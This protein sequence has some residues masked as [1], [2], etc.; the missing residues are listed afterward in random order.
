MR[1][2]LLWAMLLLGAL[3]AHASV[4]GLEAGVP[5][6]SAAARRSIYEGL[7]H[8]RDGDDASASAAFDSA[9][10]SSGF[11]RIEDPLQY[12]ALRNA[13]Q[14]A[15]KQGHPEAAH[16]LLVRA[17]AFGEATADAWYARAD[18]AFQSGNNRDVARCVTAV[19]KR[20]PDGM[21]WNDDGVF[22]I[23]HRL[24]QD[25]AGREDL[26]S[27]LQALFDAH[28]QT[29]EGEPSP[30]W[31][32]L[33]L[34]L[35]EQ[36][37]LAKA[38]EVASRIASARIA[39]SLRVD[40][41]F[42]PITRGRP[43]IDITRIAEKEIRADR[44]AALASED[45]LQPWVVLLRALDALGQFDETVKI[46]DGIMARSADGAGA[47]LYRDFDDQ[48]PWLLDERAR[49]LTGLGR[50]DDAVLQFTRAMR[51]PENGGMNVSQAINLGS[52]YADLQRPREALDAVAE[53]GEMSPYGRMQLEMVRYKATRLLGDA[54]ATDAH[55]AYLRD[56]HDDAI[57]TWQEVLLL[58]GQRDQA[59]GVFIDR[60]NDTARRAS[61][62]AEVQEYA[63]IPQTPNDARIATERKALLDRPDVRAALERVG[64]VERF[65][66]IPE[67]R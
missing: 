4:G 16:P 42:D 1:R 41:R 27:M 37:D 5:D 3:P 47:S 32:T 53:A 28:W 10:H 15:L 9:I 6:P 19:A 60:L 13:G 36:A 66:L 62:L 46:A 51:R 56:H 30:L 25:P 52:L 50:W 43:P 23:H 14:L 11:E 55:F 12:L 48:Y 38:S 31:E 26:Q 2:M 44:K 58:T 54:S 40:K 59:A 21:A 63:D 35:I 8:V 49:A 20:W 22:A 33:S 7:A 39:M 34:Q 65:A 61:A 57:A 45:R 17:T 67:P 18:A 29:G 64:R 24:K